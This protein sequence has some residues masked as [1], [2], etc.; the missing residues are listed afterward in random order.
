MCAEIVETRPN[1][2]ML[3]PFEIQARAEHLGLEMKT[4]YERAG[5]CGSVFQRW[6]RGGDVRMSTYI[7]LCEAT[8]PSWARNIR[9]PPGAD[10]MD[11]TQAEV[12]RVRRMA[13]PE[14]AAS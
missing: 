10:P 2:Y 14:T 1:P 8:A 6:R 5:I 12:E 9:K 4:V 11:A 7:K 3:S 13:P